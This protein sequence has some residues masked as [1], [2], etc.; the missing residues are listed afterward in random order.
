[1]GLEQDLYRRYVVQPERIVNLLI[2]S[3]GMTE[4]IDLFAGI[5]PQNPELDPWIEAYGVYWAERWPD[6][7]VTIIERES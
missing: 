5:L 7:I 6:D 2:L 4:P 1:M 3:F